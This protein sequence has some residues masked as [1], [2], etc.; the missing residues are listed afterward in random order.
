MCMCMQ[1]IKDKILATCIICELKYSKILSDNKQ[2]KKQ[3]QQKKIKSKK[4]QRYEN[5]I[6][7]MNENEK[8]DVEAFFS[9]VLIVVVVIIM[10]KNEKKKIHEITMKSNSVIFFSFR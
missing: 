6:A 7:E 3:Q 5:G 10:P 2:C 1:S 9:D 4:K 8:L